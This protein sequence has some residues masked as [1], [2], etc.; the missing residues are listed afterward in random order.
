MARGSGPGSSGG[1][2]RGLVAAAPA[3]LLDVTMRAD[4]AESQSKVNVRG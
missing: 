4:Q 1:R 3:V 2:A